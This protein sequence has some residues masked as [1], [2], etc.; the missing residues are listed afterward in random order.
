[1]SLIIVFGSL[2]PYWEKSLPH[3]PT[4]LEPDPFYLPLILFSDFFKKMYSGSSKKWQPAQLWPWFALKSHNISLGN[5]L[6]PIVD[7]LFG[8]MLKFNLSSLLHPSTC[9]SGCSLGISIYFHQDFSEATGSIWVL[10]LSVTVPPNPQE[11]QWT[12]YPFSISRERRYSPMLFVSV[13]PFW[14]NTMEMYFLSPLRWICHLTS[15][16]QRNVLEVTCVALD[17][18]F[19]LCLP[20]IITSIRPEI[21]N[22]IS[23]PSKAKLKR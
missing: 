3:L 4:T 7:H 13:S 17:T 20:V 11:G 6:V 10:V 12:E 22:F 1:M 2:L 21:S 15:L 8:P 14:G 23:L 16:G 5:Y 19:Y 9:I 18:Q